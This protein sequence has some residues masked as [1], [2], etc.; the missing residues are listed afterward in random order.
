MIYLIAFILFLILLFLI[1]VLRRISLKIIAIGTLLI[2]FCFSCVLFFKKP[3]L[4]KPFNLN[5]IEKV[6]K[7][8]PDGSTSIIQTTTVREVKKK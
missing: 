5:V 6:I 4:H 1:I 7:I 3:D 8:N 2:L